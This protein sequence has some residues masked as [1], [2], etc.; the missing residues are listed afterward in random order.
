MTLHIPTMFVMVMLAT[1]ATCASLAL[2]A[3]RGQ[4]E[5]AVWSWALLAQLVA[6]LLFALRDAVPDVLSIVVA[7]V[8]VSVS[9]SVYA[10]GIHRFD[11]RPVPWRALFAPA[12][13]IA[14]SFAFMLDDFVGRMIVGGVV[15][16]GQSLH[17]LGLLLVRRR[18]TIGRGQYLLMLAAATYAMAMVW[19]LIAVPL[20]LDG[21]VSITDATPL[22]IFNFLSSLTSTLLLSFGAL[23]M[24]FERAHREAKDSEQ[25]YRRLIEAANEGIMILEGGRIR[26]VNPRLCALMGYEERDLLDRPFLDLVHPDDRAAVMQ[27]HR[28]RLDGSAD[29]LTYFGRGLTRK[30]GER[31]FRVSGVLIDWH[32]RPASL[33]FLSDV[34]EQREA[35]KR[36]HDLAFHDSLTGLPNRR[37]FFDRLQQALAAASRS[38]R[39]VAVVFLDLDN[40][41]SLNDRYGHAAG[42]Q[43]LRE[44][45]RR[46]T[47]RLRESD[48]AARFGGDE[49][50]VLLTELA[51]GLDE[52]RSQ[53]RQ[54][55]DTL[56]PALAEPYSLDVA[57]DRLPVPVVH[58]CELS[59]G[60]AIGLL[61]AAGARESDLLVDR[62]DS[63]MYRA[64]QAGRNRVVFDGDPL[65]REETAGV[66][67]Q[68]AA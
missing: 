36:I 2:I 7:N 39:R 44:V 31:W 9:I 1:A 61:P 63:A 20:G 47:A 53:I 52:A 38:G 35:A 68:P 15:F 32:G 58:R 46:L 4:R 14:V 27:R 40:F 24:V 22:A 3:R 43:L 23:A 37:L 48:T 13:V 11:G 62:A 12:A 51:P 18:R 65:S 49:F 19:R 29:G 59:A 55:L 60:V 67:G 17:L 56:M 66:P 57:R 6:Y 28:E 50:V 54:L 25:R 30:H 8:L 64:K 45:A 10:V 21:A 33:N 16:L 34:T 26:M 5:L 42:D 41:K